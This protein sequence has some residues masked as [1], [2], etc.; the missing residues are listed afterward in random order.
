[1]DSFVPNKDAEMNGSRISGG[2]KIS[3]KGSL[4]NSAV[5]LRE[6]SPKK[7]ANFTLKVVD[8]EVINTQT[9]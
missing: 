4:R 6:E 9:V 3:N 5:Q 2:K 1:M 7:E 8:T